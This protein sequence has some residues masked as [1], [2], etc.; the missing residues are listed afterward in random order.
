MEQAEYALKIS[1]NNVDRA[2]KSLQRT[3]DN[4]SGGGREP[5][6]P[7][8]PRETRPKRFEKKTEDTKPSSAKVSLFDFLEDKLPAQSDIPETQGTQQHQQQ[9]R[10]NDKFGHWAENSNFERLELRGSEYSSHAGKGG[11]YVVH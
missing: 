7:R 4:R 2:L 10:S 11:R 9:E 8:E 5:R 3:S 6:E 1:R